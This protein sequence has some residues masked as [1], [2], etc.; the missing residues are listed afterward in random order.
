MSC[1]WYSRVGASGLNST[2]IF[3]FSGTYWNR[4]YNTIFIGLYW[5]M[6]LK[7]PFEELR[8]PGHESIFYSFEK[9]FEPMLWFFILS[10]KF[11]PLFCDLWT[12]FFC[13]QT[14]NASCI[15]LTQFQFHSETSYLSYLQNN[16]ISFCLTWFEST[17]N[18]YWLSMS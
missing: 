12:I 15:C 17:S 18:Y 16:S 6:F 8:L 4:K 9:L 11:I 10:L 5:N 7:N 14:L 13:F 3:F 1:C 2:C